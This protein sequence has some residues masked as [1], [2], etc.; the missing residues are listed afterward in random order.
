MNNRMMDIPETDTFPTPAELA[1]TRRA[2]ASAEVRALLAKI[3]G[4]LER[5]GPG[6]TTI[7]APSMPAREEV[8]RIL[9]TKGWMVEFGDDQRDGSWVRVTAIE[10]RSSTDAEWHR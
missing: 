5:T 2:K 7:D 9:S 10:P 1:A 8:Q 3:R 4:M 6:S